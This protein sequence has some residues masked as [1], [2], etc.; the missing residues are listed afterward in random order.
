MTRFCR[1][2][3]V[4]RDVDAEMPAPNWSASGFV[5]D[6]CCSIATFSSALLLS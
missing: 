3:D 1:P 4:R 5:A 2:L 6:I